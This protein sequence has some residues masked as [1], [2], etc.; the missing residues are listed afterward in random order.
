MTE[1]ELLPKVKNALGIQG[2][3]QDDTISEYIAEVVS[4]LTE[5]GVSAGHITAGVVARGVSDLW[6]YGSGNG[7]L[8]DYFI[9]RAAQL[10]YKGAGT[11]G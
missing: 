3:Y 1:A 10:S 4:F 9:Q 6:S 2:D 8:S 7:K 5:A 11:N